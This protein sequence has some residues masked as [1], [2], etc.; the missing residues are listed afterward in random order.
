MG[1]KKNRRGRPFASLSRLTKAVNDNV[2]KGKGVSN[3]FVR[4]FARQFCD[5]N[6]FKGVFSADRIPT[7]AIANNPRF[8]LIV[9]LATYGEPVGHFV[10]I[11]GSPKKITYIDPYGLPCLQPHVQRFLTACQ[12]PVEI[13]RKQVQHFNS[14]YCGLYAIMFLKKMER[15]IKEGGKTFTLTFYSHRQKRNDKLCMLYLQKLC[16]Q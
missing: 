1:G 12:R 8:T 13:N 5:K 9:N 11:G 6:I 7:S 3:S 15:E 2:K 14:V 4:N 10:T 16:F